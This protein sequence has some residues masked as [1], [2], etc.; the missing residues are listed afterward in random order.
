ML[1]RILISV[2]GSV[3]LAVGCLAFVAAAAPGPPTAISGTFFKGPA[4]GGRDRLAGQNVLQVRNET[5]FGSLEGGVLTGAAEYTIDEEIVNFAGGIGTL[6][7]HIALTRGD[8]S[9]ITLHLSG[10]TSGVSPKAQTVTVTGS[11]VIVSVVGPAAPL[12]GE[13]Q[14]TGIENF[15][16]GETNG[17]FSGVIH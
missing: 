8:G 15:Q 10:F 6:H 14:F 4:V 7:A 12:H 9:V 13:G 11:W 1:K 5:G 3:G 16:T 2:V 17:A